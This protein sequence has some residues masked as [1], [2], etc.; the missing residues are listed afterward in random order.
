ME[1]QGENCL[2]FQPELK[3]YYCYTQQRVELL[4]GKDIKGTIEKAAE[5]KSSAAFDVDSGN[6]IFRP[7]LPR[8]W[9][10]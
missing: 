4:W 2:G 10:N 8:S 5:G 3:I 9:K 6:V 1:S 7:R